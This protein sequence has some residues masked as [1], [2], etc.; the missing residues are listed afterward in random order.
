MTDPHRVVV[1]GGGVAGLTTAYRL[2]RAGVDVTLVEADAPG[3]KVRSEIEVGGLRLEPG[4]DSF[5]ARKPWATELCRELGLDLVA[6]GA[7]GAYLWTDHGLVAYPKDAA[8]G[9]PGDVGD[10]LG[11]PGLSRAG[12]WRAAQD[13]VRRAKR[14]ERE[15]TLGQL[16]RRRLGD[17]ATDLAIAPLLAGLH[18]GDVDRLSAPATFPELIAWERSQGS[19][20]RGSQAAA[21][22]ARRAD[23]GPMFLRPRG[24]IRRLID[25]LVRAL[26]ERVRAFS[27]G[28]SV[29]L[30][31]GALSIAFDGGG[32]LEAGAVVLA[33]GSG[34]A[35]AELLDDVAPGPAAELLA[36]RSVSTG[37]VFLVYPE[38]TQAA[39][40]DG[41]GFVVPRGKAPMTAC[42]WISSKW[43]DAEYGTRA[44]VRCFVGADGEEDVLEAD[45]ADIVDACARH[46]AAVLALPAHPET[47]AVHQW[48]SSMPQYEL[49]HADRVRRIREGLPPGI[50]VLGQSLDGAGLSDCVRAAGETADR[51]IAHGASARDEEVVR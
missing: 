28:V 43:P 49:G 13:L 9:I 27:R 23:A 34:A 41:T 30:A 12:R 15:E 51:V 16:L 20:I 47:W 26:G 44:V 10:V 42:T 46:L 38:G 36:I 8:F 50:F 31:D 22:A 7:S 25:A 18:A 14:D 35:A 29:G 37:V 39:L 32:S 33:T 48:M 45:D 1:V 4:A 21:R 11:W 2:M 24:G 19:L 5:V 40:P 3:G 17:E 6:P